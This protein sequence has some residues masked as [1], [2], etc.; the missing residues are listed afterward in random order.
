ML[1]HVMVVEDEEHIAQQTAQYLRCMNEL[2]LE[3][4]IASSA[5]EALDQMQAHP[6]DLI[7]TDIQMPGMHGLDLMHKIRRMWPLCQF[8]I[9]TAHDRFSYALDALQHQAIDYVLKSEG[10][11]RLGEAVVSAIARMEDSLA[12]SRILE[13]ARA[14]AR[15]AIPL[16]K[17][18][19][20]LDLVHGAPYSP[21]KLADTQRSLN[22]EINM[23]K[24][25]TLAMVLLHLNNGDENLLDRM[26]QEN[27]LGLLAKS[28]LPVDTAFLQTEI[29]R[30]RMLWFIQKDGCSISKP[31]RLFESIQRTCLTQ[32]ETPLSVTYAQQCPSHAN[33]R[34][35]YRRLGARQSSQALSSMTSWIVSIDSGIT[36]NAENDIEQYSASSW[37]KA[38][39]RADPTADD[40]L[41]QLLRP[42]FDLAAGGE[43]GSSCDCYMMVSLQMR[44]IF[45]SLNLQPEQGKKLRLHLLYDYYAHE[46]PQAAHDY[47][48]NLASAAAS[49]HRQQGS[50]ALFET[51]N[52][53][54]SYIQANLGGDLSLTHLAERVSMN[55]SYLSRIYKQA[56]GM[57]LTEHITSLKI[58][59]AQ[60]LL[61]QPDILIQDI[62]RELG[63]QDASYFS[64]FFRKNCGMS[65]RQF[66]D[67]SKR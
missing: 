32:L 58:Q 40:M 46:S 42:I 24:P 59:R 50:D 60:E 17:R 51:M 1:Y 25:F 19:F 2:E 23:S 36:L 52:N 63:F 62:S 48:I 29:D 38:F 65:A 67:N 7:V 4:S 26:E 64:Y 45:D 34:L 5:A 30:H 28:Y 39:E 12:M 11:K 44:R 66:R 57:N 14:Q 8:I 6:M 53:L 37:R 21:E 22:L 9:L 15:L 54:N 41:K 31:D 13:T 61:L 3:V 35:L 18:E 49:I 56:T 20:I 47:L 10:M 27:A 33:M 16:L 43:G 55:A